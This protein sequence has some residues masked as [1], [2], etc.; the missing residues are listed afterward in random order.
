MHNQK[1]FSGIDHLVGS[2]SKEHE[3][4]ES[5]VTVQ[6]TREHEPSDAVK[7][8]VRSRSEQAHIDEELK[9]TGVRERIEAP[10][11][12]KQKELTLPLSDDM[13]VKGLHASPSSS[14][15]WL[16]EW[17]VYLLK[18]AHIVLKKAHGHVRRVIRIQ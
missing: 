16:A 12:P 11:Y 13:I 4:L 3:K 18:R 5:P 10:K 14:L 6:K 7:E 8:F 1:N 17:A 2:A 15:R 9:K